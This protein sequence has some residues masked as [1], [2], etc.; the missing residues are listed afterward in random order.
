MYPVILFK[1]RSKLRGSSLDKTQSGKRLNYK[2]THSSEG[3]ELHDIFS[4]ITVS[5]D[6]PGKD[7]VQDIFQDPPDKKKSQCKRRSFYQYSQ[8]QTEG[9]EGRKFYE[10]GKKVFHIWKDDRKFSVI[11]KGIAQNEGYYKQEKGWN[12]SKK[13]H[14]KKLGKDELPFA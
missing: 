10:I 2:I 3:K 5:K 12:K 1:F 9:K 13:N 14:C 7:A 8:K 4:N 11:W 6:P